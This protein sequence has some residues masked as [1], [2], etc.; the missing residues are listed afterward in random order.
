MRL[1]VGLL[2]EALADRFCIPPTYCSNIFK[3]WI[4]FL[5][6]MVGKLEAWFLEES[7]METSGKTWSGKTVG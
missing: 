1:R 7:V 2:N 5:S 3:T 6:K 4:R